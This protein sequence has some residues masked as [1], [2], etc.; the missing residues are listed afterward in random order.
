MGLYGAGCD[1][2]RPSLGRGS[3]LDAHLG[4]RSRWG[5]GW[6]HRCRCW[7]PLLAG[8][9]HAPSWPRS[10]PPAPSCHTPG[11]SVLAAGSPGWCQAGFWLRWEPLQKETAAGARA[12][13][14]WACWTWEG[15][16]VVRCSR[17]FAALP[18]GWVLG[19]WR[20][21]LQEC[22]WDGEVVVHRRKERAL[23]RSGVGLPSAGK[24]MRSQ[25]R[26]GCRT[27]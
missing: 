16:P 7:G 3:T 17:R 23:L 2:Q 18:A 21:G 15:S 8:A 4:G 25:Q 22:G 1:V 19:F 20:A 26:L 14:A 10:A 12:S 6:E 5:T 9:G 27:W 24:G 11:V 13:A